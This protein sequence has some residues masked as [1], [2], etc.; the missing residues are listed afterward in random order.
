MA[1]PVFPR[2]PVAGYNLKAVINGVFYGTVD[3][4]IRAYCGDLDVSDSEG[5]DATGGFAQ[6]ELHIAAQKALQVTIRNATF[7]RANNPFDAPISLDAGVNLSIVIFLYGSTGPNWS[8]PVVLVTSVEQ[9][10]NV[11]QGQPISFS[12]ITSGRY[13]PPV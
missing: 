7:D 2:V 6:F 3:Y 12:G 13:T 10:G 1:F 4:N 11:K 5:D 9:T 8:L